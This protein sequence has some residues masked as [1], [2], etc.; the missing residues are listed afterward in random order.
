MWT[1]DVDEMHSEKRCGR[2]FLNGRTRKS[3]LLATEPVPSQNVIES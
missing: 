1:W 2:E 3:R